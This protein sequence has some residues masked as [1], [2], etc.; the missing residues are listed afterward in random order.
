MRQPIS[1][2]QPEPVT[3]NP[4]HLVF[5]L[6]LFGVDA[7]T[8][9]SSTFYFDRF[10]E[11]T[12]K[13]QAVYYRKTTWNEGAWQVRDYYKNGTLQMK[14]KY[15]DYTHTEQQDTFEYYYPNGALKRKGKFVNG[16]Y[17]GVWLGWLDDGRKDFKCTYK[18]NTHKCAYFHENG[19]ISAVEEYS[20]DTNLVSAMFRDSTG[21]ESANLYI[22]NQPA[23][24]GEVVDWYKLFGDYMLFPED[25][26][27][28]RLYGK[29]DFFIT[30]DKQGKVNMGESI[31]FVHPEMEHALIRAIKKFPVCTPA[32][33]HNRVV[34]FN[35]RLRFNFTSD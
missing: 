32:I 18:E 29:V 27:G 28:N 25:I 35:V 6:M 10:W 14:G 2:A 11:E 22:E 17:T 24:H 3:M 12:D 4:R 20:N 23:L 16:R 21:A 33:Y 30:I 1:C 31:G 13:Q 15:S 26:Q 19:L 5:I 8:Q 9:D 7:F 34:E